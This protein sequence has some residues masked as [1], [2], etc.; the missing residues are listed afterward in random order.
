MRFKY[1]SIAKDLKEIQRKFEP[2]MNF[3]K[4]KLAENIINLIIPLFTQLTLDDDTTNN[5]CL[6]TKE[7]SSCM[8]S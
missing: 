5:K 4:K 8:N 6:S 2:K 1:Q 3:Q 7:I